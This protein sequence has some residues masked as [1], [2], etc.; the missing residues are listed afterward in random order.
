[1]ELDAAQRIQHF[2]TQLITAHGTAAL[3]EQILDIVLA[4][5]HAGF[6]SIEDSTL[7]TEPR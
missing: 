1:M 2:A 6:A 5:V 4:I 7:R 3:Y